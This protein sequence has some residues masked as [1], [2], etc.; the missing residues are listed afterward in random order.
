MALPL[1]GLQ[2]LLQVQICCKGGKS[3]TY[4]W[5]K[6]KLNISKVA[7]AP[8]DARAACFD[9]STTR[10]ICAAR[11]QLSEVR[12][13]ERES[14]CLAGALAACRDRR[15]NINKHAC[16]LCALL[17]YPDYSR[18]MTTV[19]CGGFF[20]HWELCISFSCLFLIGT[21]SIIPAFC[22]YITSSFKDDPLT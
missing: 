21:F 12:M 8:P 7:A 5:K 9:V 3:K 4:I 20:F 17:H 11:E 1:S 10:E 16:A 2:V 14:R 6:I 22:L 13:S 18:V 15:T 19:F